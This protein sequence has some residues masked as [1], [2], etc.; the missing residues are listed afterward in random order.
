MILSPEECADLLD[1]LPP[2]CGAEA[3]WFLPLPAELPPIEQ[4]C[5]ELQRH[6]KAWGLSAEEFDAQ[7]G[8]YGVGAYFP[9]HTDWDPSR[10]DQHRA[11]TCA[12]SVLLS[13]PDSYAGGDLLL[14]GWDGP[15]RSRGEVLCFPGHVEHEVTP[16]TAGTRVSLTVFG[17]F[18]GTYADAR[19]ARDQGS[20]A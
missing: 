1:Y 3:V 5:Q 13:D 8:V 17:V 16:V 11:L 9:R 19:R 6:A 4:V 2:D 12:T 15:S 14:Y 18:A 7:L 10:G 20:V